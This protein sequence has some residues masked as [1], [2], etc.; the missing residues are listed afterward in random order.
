MKIG[1]H[2]LRF[3]I[4][5]FA[6]SSLLFHPPSDFEAFAATSDATIDSTREINYSTTSLG[7][8][9]SDN[10]GTNHSDVLSRSMKAVELSRFLT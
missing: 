9:D 4:L 1:M 5:L 6:A 3:F 8:V 2:N 7:L 10:F